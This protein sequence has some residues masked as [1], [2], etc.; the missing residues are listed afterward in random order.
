[1]KFLS[2][3]F[4]IVVTCLSSGR[5]TASPADVN[6]FIG[7]W[8]GDASSTYS[9][10]KTL[11]GSCENQPTTLR[12]YLQAGRLVVFGDDGCSR[13]LNS[14]LTIAFSA[15]I[16]DV[17]LVGNKISF[18]WESDIFDVWHKRFF[19]AELMNG[20]ISVKFTDESSNLYWTSGSGYDDRFVDF[21]A[22]RLGRK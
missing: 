4:L 21:V 16:S 19:S 18:V 9:H 2:L 10:W 5:A 11:K 8:S 7:T 20:A 12:I 6:S 15:K 13:S 22:P 17:T 3:L 14:D 1:M